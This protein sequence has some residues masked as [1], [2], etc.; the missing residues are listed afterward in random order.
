[1]GFDC[2]LFWESW[3]TYHYFSVEVTIF[4]FSFHKLCKKA[5]FSSIEALVRYT[6]LETVSENKTVM[7]KKG[8]WWEPVS[9]AR[10]NS[11][12]D[13]WGSFRIPEDLTSLKCLACQWNYSPLINIS[14]VA[15]QKSEL[16]GRTNHFDNE[17]G[18]YKECF[19]KTISL[20]LAI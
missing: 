4:L 9:S 5:I 17:I 1:M 20:V 16:A 12:Q 8:F 10:E 19:W 15:F 13:R 14:K 18:F 7:M 11:G 2:I 6:G 3:T